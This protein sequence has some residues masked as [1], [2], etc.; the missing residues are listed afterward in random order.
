MA[1]FAVGALACVFVEVVFDLGGGTAHRFR[2]FIGFDA[3]IQ[4]EPLGI[5]S[6]RL[7]KAFRA[8][9]V[10][11]HLERSMIDMYDDELVRFRVC[12]N[13]ADDCAVIDDT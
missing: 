12:S 6:D 3:Q 8:P 2:F 7:R 11:D 4:R 5:E 10:P 1:R 13:D 9:C